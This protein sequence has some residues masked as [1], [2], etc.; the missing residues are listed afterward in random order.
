MTAIPDGRA[1]LGGR[2]RRAED[3]PG[4]VRR[5]GLLR[6]EA[7]VKVRRTEESACTPGIA[8]PTRPSSFAAA[9]PGL[10]LDDF[11]LATLEWVDWFSDRRLHS[12][13]GNGPPVKYEDNYYR[14]IADLIGTRSRALSVE[15][16]YPAGQ[17]TWSFL[18]WGTRVPEVSSEDLLRHR[19]RFGD[20]STLCVMT[21][22]PRPGVLPSRGGRGAGR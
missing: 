2:G 3:R 10:G 11:E 21:F 16:G 9:A 4:L 18:A 5:F 22:R 13:H 1:A 14:S 17:R 8:V 15:I 20:R 19:L 12:A 7:Q 6:T